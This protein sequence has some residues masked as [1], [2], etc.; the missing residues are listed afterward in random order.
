MREDGEHIELNFGRHFEKVSGLSVSGIEYQVSGFGCQVSGIRYQVSGI[1]SD[2]VNG[3]LPS[4]FCL[5]AYC[6]LLSA[7]CHLPT[8][9]CFLSLLTLTNLYSSITDNERQGRASTSHS[10]ADRSWADTVRLTWLSFR[11]RIPNFTKPQHF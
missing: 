2:S 7:Y 9:Y 3:L 5:L 10:R 11:K 6:L 1:R 8:A 4:A